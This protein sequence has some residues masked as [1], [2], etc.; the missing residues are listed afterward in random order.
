V[1]C[2]EADETHYWEP[3]GND[4]GDYFAGGEGEEDG[5]ADE[6]IT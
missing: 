3:D 2:S 4:F 6:P 5:H 1:I